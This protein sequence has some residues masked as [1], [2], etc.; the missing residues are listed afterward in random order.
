MYPKVGEL[1]IPLVGSNPLQNLDSLDIL[2]DA[3]DVNETPFNVF[4]GHNLGHRVF[5]MSVPF[6]KFADISAVANNREAGPVAQR[7]LDENHAKKLSVYMVKGL[8]SAAK[9]RRIATGKPVPE[10]FDAILRKLG[11]QP[12]F[13]LQPLVCNIRNVP[14]GGNGAGG[15]R[16]FRLETSAGET[17]AFKVF[18]SERHILWVV[19]GQHRRHAADM[20]MTFLEQVRQTGKYPGKGAVLFVEKGKQV[21]EEEMLVWNEAYEAARSY[22]TLTVEVHLGLDIDQERQLF[23]D[24]NRLGKKV[25]ASLAF[26]FDGSNPITHFIKHKLAGELGISITETEAKDWSEDSGALVLKDMVA[27][28]AIAFL[29]KG[30]VAGATPA[31][32]EPREEV[33]LN[34]WSRIVEIPEF[35]NHRAKEK[36]VAAQPVILKAL[37]KITYDLNFSNRRPEDAD[38]QFAQ[39]LEKI[40]SIDFSH[41]NPMW[42]FYSLT[43]GKR[44]DA[45]LGTLADYLP[46]DT[47]GVNRDIGSIQSGGF[48]RFGAKHNDIFPILADMIRWAAGLPSRRA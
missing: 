27:V 46:E 5:T 42:N 36:T 16:G 45:G 17:A 15:I 23:H 34:L 40:P 9:I 32:I 12:Y 29:N 13:S 6:R 20:V 25:D 38:V 43:D 14:P 21:S 24:L 3:G 35:G 47:Q 48:M 4:I 44:L 26:Q 28:N 10:T 19:D 2:A 39:L 33:A 8:V 30:N 31:V 18:L 41:Q 7:A 22:A 37:A 1:P 11:E